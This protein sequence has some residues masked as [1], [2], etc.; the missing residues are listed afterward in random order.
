MIEMLL[1]KIETVNPALH[2]GGVSNWL[3]QRSVNVV[4]CIVIGCKF[5][6]TD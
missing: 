3:R 6:I 5:L 4:N 1:S 2:I